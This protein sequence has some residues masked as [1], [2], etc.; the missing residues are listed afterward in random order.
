MPHPSVKWDVTDLLWAHEQFCGPQGRQRPVG[1]GLW[2]Q[3]LTLGTPHPSKLTGVLRTSLPFSVSLFHTGWLLNF[4]FILSV[5][6]SLRTTLDLTFLLSRLPQ[7][8]TR[9]LRLT[10]LHTKNVCRLWWLWP[11]NWRRRTTTTSSASQ[12]GKTMSS[13]SGSTCWS[14]SGP[15][16]SASRWTWG[17]RRYS[18]KCSTSWTGWMKWR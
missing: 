18:R 6:F 17:C 1:L 4:V 10:S 15:G 8:S 11:G 13:G 14:C 3:C 16:D 12:H 7:K 9:P 2:I 5:P